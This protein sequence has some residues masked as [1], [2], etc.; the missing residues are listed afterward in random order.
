M[1][2]KKAYLFIGIVLVILFIISRFEF[3]QMRYQPQQFAEAIEASSSSAL[4][5]K[6]KKIDG[7]T[8]HY[9]QLGDNKELP[10]VFLVHGSPGA[11]SAY[12]DYLKD[13]LLNQRANLIAIDRPGFGYSDFG[14]AISSLSHQAKGIAT[15]L[16]DF[17]TNQ[18]VIVGH[19]MGGPVISR[20]V[21]DYP[22]LVDGLILVAP[23]ISPAL[24]PSNKWRIVLDYL[25]FRWLT[26]TAFRVC[27]QE[28]IPLKSELL[29][30]E[31]RWNTITCPVTIIQGTADPLVPKG[32]AY[33]AKEQLVNSAN[34]Q[35]EMI[36]E[37]NHF[38]LWS[39]IPLIRNAI[40]K[41]LENI[42]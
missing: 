17:P 12:K 36:E 41:M 10:L 2:L 39:E 5:F 1:V 22:D 15:I 23:S 27:N 24:E 31:N 19:S 8:F 13:T 26:P 28:I 4:V 3:L 29:E 20:L 32:N 11:L 37:G 34:V 38:I 40:L 6:K 7:T 16:K 30:M 21:M 35:L 25:L 18:K 14:T 9:C 33:F 42:K